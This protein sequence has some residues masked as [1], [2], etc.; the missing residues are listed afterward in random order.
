M[1]WNEDQASKWKNKYLL[2]LQE[3]EE[4]EKIYKE[5]DTI[6]RE[7]IIRISQSTDQS[8]ARLNKQLEVLRKHIS[9]G[10]SALKLRKA[11]EEISISIS[12]LQAK[13]KENQPV[14]DLLARLKR[15]I[16]KLLEKDFT[17]KSLQK[18][19]KKIDKGQSQTDVMQFID[20]LG[21][22]LATELASLKKPAAKGF[23]LFGRKNTEPETEAE[24]VVEE[25]IPLVE[26]I[27]TPVA[28]VDAKTALDSLISRMLLPADLQVEANLIR[29]GLATA[30]TEQDVLDA[31]GKTVE[32]VAELFRRVRREREEIEN[33]LKQ[34]S[35]RL[36]EMDVD[37]KT[38]LQLHEK[39]DQH[40]QEMN[41]VINEGM[42]GINDD[43]RE[44][45]DFEQL[46]SSIQSRVI[47]I[48]NKLD[49][50]VNKEKDNRHESS[51]LVKQ[52]SEKVQNL[53]QEAQQLKQE[54]EKRQAEAMTDALTA[55]PNRYS[56][57]DRIKLELARFKR[58]LTPFCMMVWDID[59]FK[60]INDSYG[61]A[62]GDRVLKIVADMLAKNIRETD[63]ISR[64]GGEEFVGILADT[65]ID[66]AM[67]VANKLRTL[68]E[69]CEFHFRDKRVVVTASCGISQ[70]RDGDDM[71]ILFKRSDDA[72]YQAKQQGRNRVVAG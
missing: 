52:L 63:F 61:H 44:Y 21:D 30:Q 37:L 6:L 68:I 43:L 70:V 49:E 36:N 22:I 19:Y 48:R 67:Q 33:F 11:I 60:K 71:E 23:S 8:H 4:K 24:T 55:L 39:S 69:Q 66:V 18:L 47:V 32:L 13:Q 41:S 58:H 2:S 25:V 40:S 1:N 10:V 53:E 14:R 26:E 45:R 16:N 31:F 29:R 12:E 3:Q 46:K 54:L 65:N 7:L 59:F 17:P 15:N 56:Y 57:D 38:S 35:G 27:Q 42:S 20:E 64:F 34:L 50:V 5:S 62:A 28:E 9:D 72:L 51:G